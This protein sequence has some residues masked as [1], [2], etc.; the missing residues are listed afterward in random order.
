MTTTNWCADGSVEFGD[1]LTPTADAHLR[2]STSNTNKGDTGATVSA[3]GNEED[4][5]HS[6]E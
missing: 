6:C 1:E 4:M 2:P 5:T 3:D